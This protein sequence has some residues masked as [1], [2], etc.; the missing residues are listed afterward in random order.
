M[1]KVGARWGVRNNVFA[2]IIS[3]IQRQLNRKHRTAGGIVVDAN[4]T[5]MFA[6]NGVGDGQAKAGAGLAGGKIRF[7]NAQFD[8]IGN[9][10]AIIGHLK[11]Q[12]E[13]SRENTPQLAKAI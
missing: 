12:F 4:G 2:G 8:L 6:Y 1:D 5:A 9:A 7:E 11:Q 10:R 13:G 3:G